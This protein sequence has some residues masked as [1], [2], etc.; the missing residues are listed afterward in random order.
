[1]KKWPIVFITICLAVCFLPFVGMAAWPTTVTTEN[2]TLSS[3]PQ[4]QG[5]EGGLNLKF[6]SEF[7]TWFHEHFAFRNQLV[8]ADAR[9]QGDIFRVSGVDGVVYGKDDWLYYSSTLSDYLG[10]QPLSPREVYNVA[11]NLE[12]TKDY[13]EARGCRFLLTVPPNKNT[14]YGE[15][16]P[17][18]DS[19]IVTKEHA[20][21]KLTPLLEEKGIPYA[22]LFALF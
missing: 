21:D 13:V 12:L 17:Y 7:E 10:G 14:L 9:I 16:M 2:R 11:H 3:F 5:K 6:F 20:I 18:Y 1:M 4:L 19:L 8:Y 22:D 15:N